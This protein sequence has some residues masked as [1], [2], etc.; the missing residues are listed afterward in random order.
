MQ[1]LIGN[2]KGIST[3][4]QVDAIGHYYPLDIQEERYATMTFK[5]QTENRMVYHL[6]VAAALAGNQRIYDELF[7]PKRYHFKELQ[8]AFEIMGLHNSEINQRWEA[9]R[10]YRERTELSR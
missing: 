4:W 3:V 10:I 9:M 6:A 2:Q 8:R 5:G 1:D 7:L